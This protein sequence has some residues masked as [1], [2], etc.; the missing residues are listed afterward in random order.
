[1]AINHAHADDRAAS[2]ATSLLRSQPSAHSTDSPTPRSYS[3]NEGVPLASSYEDLRQSVELQLQELNHASM[4]KLDT[5]VPNKKILNRK[6]AIFILLAGC[7]LSVLLVAVVNL[8]PRR[9]SH[10]SPDHSTPSDNVVP[11]EPPVKAGVLP[12]S[13]LDPVHDLHLASFN[14]HEDSSPPKHMF[15]KRADDSKSPL[16][17]PHYEPVPTN[18]WYQNFLMLR[19]EPSNVH[20][21][22]STPYLVDV[23]GPVPG[24]RANSNHILSSTSVL[25]LTFNEE[26]G[27]TLGA[28]PRFADKNSS[29]KNNLDYKYRAL[30][31]TQ[32]GLT[33]KWV[34]RLDSLYAIC[35]VS[36]LYYYDQA[37]Q[38]PC[39]LHF[40]RTS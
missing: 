30:E 7:I 36:T 15:V 6:N 11:T 9:S 21:A 25:Q 13:L 3:N 2:E 39:F 37:D 28:A 22:Y 40:F 35:L 20:R 18:A 32:L 5:V 19:G 26:F 23:V 33:L 24:L 27:L 14:R 17:A 29:K 38:N 4:S 1:M 8:K 16:D 34:S 12:F 31:T 10:N